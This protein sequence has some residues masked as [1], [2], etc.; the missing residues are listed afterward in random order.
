MTLGHLNDPGPR[1]RMGGWAIRSATI[2]PGVAIP[3]IRK[4][5]ARNNNIPP[6]WRE[7]GNVHLNTSPKIADARDKETAMRSDAAYMEA[8]MQRYEQRV[9]DLEEIEVEL[10]EK[11]TLLEQGWINA[12]V[13]I[14]N[15]GQ[16]KFCYART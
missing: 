12:V 14:I 7:N 16:D 15:N 2:F 13:T 4:P 9:F 6:E 3:R 5:L 1:Y 10:R 8:L 11:L